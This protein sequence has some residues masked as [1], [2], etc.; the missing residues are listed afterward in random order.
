MCCSTA[1]QICGPVGGSNRASRRLVRVWR[2][3]LDGDVRY[4]YRPDREHRRDLCQRCGLSEAYA[5]LSRTRNARLAADDRPV[6]VEAALNLDHDPMARLVGHDELLLAR[7]ARAG[8]DGRGRA[9]ERSHVRLE[10]ELALPS[11][12]SAEVGL[13]TRTGDARG[14][15][16]S[17]RSPIERRTGPAVVDQTV[18]FSPSHWGEDRVGLDWDRVRRWSGHVAAGDDDLGGLRGR[19]P[20][21]L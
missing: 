21:R 6:A 5:P 1:Q 9:C 8:P 18:T 10:V 7:G 12:A 16:A 4:L 13:T 2:H 14:A 3:R 20:R 19:R 15:G 17:L 11:E